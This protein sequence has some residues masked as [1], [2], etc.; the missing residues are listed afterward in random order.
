MDSNSN[1]IFCKI[2]S[3]EIPANIVY[4]DEDFLGFLDINPVAEGHTLF[5]SK[6]HFDNLLDV[7]EEF[8][9]KFIFGLQ[10]VGKELMRKYDS[11]GF[12]I[13]LNNGES[14][15]QVV[16]HVHFHLLPRKKG[17]NKKG[18]FIG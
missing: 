11:D 4:E 16:K 9:E 7:D 10:K 8:G 13:V 12:N 18:I 6:K 5:I 15:G 2:V 14:A 1:C 3:G 17:D